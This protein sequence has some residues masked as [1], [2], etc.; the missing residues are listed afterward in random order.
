MVCTTLALGIAVASSGR[1]PPGLPVWLAVN[2]TPFPLHFVGTKIGAHRIR[3]D[4]R[5]VFEAP[6]AADTPRGVIRYTF[7]AYRFYPGHG[8]LRGY[9]RQGRVVRGSLGALVYCEVFGGRELADTRL[10]VS[11][12]QNV[13]DGARLDGGPCPD[14]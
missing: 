3:P 11:I 14:T 6:F 1:Q 13:A 10:V 9:N 7:K 5:Y 12:V 2:E 4:E 8:S